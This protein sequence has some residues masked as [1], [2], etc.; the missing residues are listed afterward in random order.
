[1]WSSGM[2]SAPARSAG[3]VWVRGAS[4]GG[5]VVAQCGVWWMFGVKLLGLVPV[6]SD[7]VFVIYVLHC[8]LNNVWHFNFE[9]GRFNFGSGGCLC[10]ERGHPQGWGS[11]TYAFHVN[12]EVPGPQALETLC[13][14]V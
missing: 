7:F 11:K 1:M 4:C 5:G 9:F 2:G 12:M 3:I 14:T 6:E 10:L 8:A 13:F